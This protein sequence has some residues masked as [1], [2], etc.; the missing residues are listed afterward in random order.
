MFVSDSSK[1]A[2]YYTCLRQLL[3]LHDYRNDSPFVESKV[4][5][6][7][8]NCLDDCHAF[9]P[10]II[11]SWLDMRCPF[12]FGSRDPPPDGWHHGLPWFVAQN[13]G[14]FAKR[15]RTMD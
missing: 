8:M 12:E 4:V 7:Y 13:E 15:R 5:K 3:E 6:W 1:L 2:V 14:R 9:H 11:Y 10:H